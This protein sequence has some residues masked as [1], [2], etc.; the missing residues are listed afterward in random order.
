MSLGCVME[1]MWIVAQGLGIGFHMV[2]AFGW[3]S[4]EDEVKRAL[5]IPES[6]KIAYAVRLGYPASEPQKYLRV[7]QDIEGFTYHDRF[8]DTRF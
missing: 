1:N 8:G 7:C 4:V 5:K 6:M 3:G 2:S